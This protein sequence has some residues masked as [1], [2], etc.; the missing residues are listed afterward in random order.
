M[1]FAGSKEEVRNSFRP[2]G[3]ASLSSLIP[4]QFFEF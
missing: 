3:K 2:V 1:T 4:V